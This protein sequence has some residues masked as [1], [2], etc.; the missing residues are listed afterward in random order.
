MSFQYAN[1]TVHIH[2]GERE[3]NETLTP[4]TSHVCIRKTLQMGKFVHFWIFGMCAKMSP[5][6]GMCTNWKTWR[7]ALELWC[8]LGKCL[9]TYRIICWNRALSSTLY[10]LDN[11]MDGWMDGQMAIFTSFNQ[12]IWFLRNIQ[13]FITRSD[14]ALAQLIRKS[15]IIAANDVYDLAYLVAVRSSSDTHAFVNSCGALHVYCTIVTAV[16]LCFRVYVRARICF[17][18]FTSSS[19]SIIHHIF[20][21]IH[22]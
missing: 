12:W 3:K 17:C 21:V 22:F 1:D 18:V 20:V 16:L 19:V 5:A 13:T 14:I 15:K 9:F 7:K 11:W 6:H 4:N 2:M 8:R 10:P